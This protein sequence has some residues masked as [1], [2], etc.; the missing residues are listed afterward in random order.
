MG[1]S[2]QGVT[3]GRQGSRRR[4]EFYCA[5][6][7][8]TLV[9]FLRRVRGRMRRRSPNEARQKRQRNLAALRNRAISP[10]AF[11]APGKGAFDI[12]LGK[13]GAR[14]SVGGSTGLFRRNEY[15]GRGECGGV[16]ILEQSAQRRRMQLY[17]IS[18]IDS[19]KSGKGLPKIRALRSIVAA[20][21]IGRAGFPSG[22][23]MIPR[24]RRTA[25]LANSDT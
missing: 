10:D 18:P 5:A 7:T 2:I 12:E 14:P 17:L 3:S 20:R 22:P 1:L 19:G 23:R 6:T 8:P 16:R 15:G 4:I 9:D 21:R 25:P 13:W 11:Y 24:A